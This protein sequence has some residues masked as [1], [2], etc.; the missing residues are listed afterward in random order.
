MDYGLVSVLIRP[1]QAFVLQVYKLVI[2][3][4]LVKQLV[5]LYVRALDYNIEIVQDIMTRINAMVCIETKQ[6]ISKSNIFFSIVIGNWS[7]W[8]NW[9]ACSVSCGVGFQ[10]QTRQC[11]GA[12]FGCV[13]EAINTM[14]C[15][16]SIAC[17]GKTR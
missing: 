10:Y 14:T 17:P 1:V 9:S 16:T 3:I 6:N 13:G 7:T 11:L 4:V 2:E 15:N 12:G 5:D 8:S